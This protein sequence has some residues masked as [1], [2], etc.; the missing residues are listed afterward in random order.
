MARHTDYDEDDSYW[1]ALYQNEHEEMQ[2]MQEV[3]RE[4][5]E[6][7]N[8]VKSAIAAMLPDMLDDFLEMS[9]DIQKISERYGESI[10]DVF[11]VYLRYTNDVATIYQWFGM[12]DFWIEREPFRYSQNFKNFMYL[13]GVQN[14][15][16]N[17]VVKILRDVMSGKAD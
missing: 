8:D 16:A 7:V 5:N 3:V 6:R 9:G 10:S 1:K 15:G 17:I 11:K 2:A 14:E 4:G 13:Y 12:S